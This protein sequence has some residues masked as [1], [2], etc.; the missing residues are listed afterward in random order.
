MTRL[1]ASTLILL[2]GFATTG[3]RHAEHLLVFG[4]E[5]HWGKARF[6]Q[7]AVGFDRLKDPACVSE[8]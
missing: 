1:A 4:R 6:R 8:R 2:G 7:A 5:F 3:T